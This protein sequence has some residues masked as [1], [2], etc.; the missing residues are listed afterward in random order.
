VRYD[1]GKLVLSTQPG[2]GVDL[3]PEKLRAL[4]GDIDA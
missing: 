4:Q 3:V 1:N 2:L